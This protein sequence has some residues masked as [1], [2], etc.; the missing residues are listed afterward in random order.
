MLQVLPAMPHDGPSKLFSTVSYTGIFNLLDYGAGV[1][2]VTAVT[3]EDEIDMAGFP[4]SD[5]WY[6]EAAKSAKVPTHSTMSVTLIQG[7][8]G[9]PVG[10]QCATPPYREE[11][12]LRILG[13]IEQAFHLA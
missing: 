1:V 6:R 12:C 13:E 8:L 5:P 11:V 7:C 10:V 9:F 3:K 2:P 4:K